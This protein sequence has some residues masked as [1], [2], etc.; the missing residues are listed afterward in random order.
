MIMMCCSSSRSSSSSSSSIAVVSIGFI[1]S[2]IMV[3]VMFREF[4]DV[5]FQDVVF[6]NDS[7]GTSY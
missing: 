3:V 4:K 5:V 2:V 6:D 7:S 1:T